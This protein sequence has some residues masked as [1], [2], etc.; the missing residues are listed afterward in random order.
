MKTKLYKQ[1]IFKALATIAL[2]LALV[3]FSSCTNLFDSVNKNDGKAYISVSLGNARRILPTDLAESDITKAELLYGTITA[4][5]ELGTWTTSDGTSAIAAMTADTSKALEVGTY[6]FTLN[7]YVGSDNSY[8]PVETGSVT[9][10]QIVAGTTNS[11]EFTM[12]Y[13][14]SGSGDLE[15]TLK[16]TKDDRVT[17]IQGG[18]FN[19]A[20]TVVTGFE[21]TALAK[22]T[23]D[24]INYTATYSKTDVPVGTYMIKFVLYNDTTVLNTLTDFVVISPECKTTIKEGWTL[25][26]VNTIYTITYNL[27]GGSWAITEPSLKTRN[28]NTGVT[29]PVYTHLWKNGY[30]FAGWYN[31]ETFTG[32]ALT[33]IK[34]GTKGDITLFAKWSNSIYVDTAEKFICAGGKSLLIKSSDGKIYIDD[35]SNGVLDTGEEEIYVT[36]KNALNG[37]GNYSDY[38]LYG[39]SCTENIPSENTS[40]ITMTM[41]AGA[42]KNIYAGGKGYANNGSVT[43]NLSAGTVS[44]NVS[45]Y[46]SDGRTSLY[47]AATSAVNISGSTVIGNKTDEGIEIDSF[48]SGYANVSSALSLSSKNITIL[49]SKTETGTSI[50]ALTNA[51]YAGADYFICRIYDSIE[52]KYNAT[53]SIEKSTTDNTIKIAS[54]VILPDVTITDSSFT[55]GANR[56]TAI[57]TILSV[58]AENGYFTLGSTGLTNATFV[59]GILNGESSY[60]NSC[61]TSNQYR[62]IQYIALNNLI[63]EADASTFVQGITFTRTS[64]NMTVKI[65]LETVPLETINSATVTYFDG[66]FYK[67]VNTSLTWQYAYIAAKNSEFNGLHGYLMTIMS[68]PENMF[69]YNKLM[70][71]NSGQSAW[72]GGNRISP[73]YFNTGKYDGKTFSTDAK[74]FSSLNAGLSCTTAWYWTCGPEAGKCFYTNSTYHENTNVGSYTHETD[75]YIPEGMFAYWNSTKSTTLTE[76]SNTNGNSSFGREICAQ[77]VSGGYWNDLPLGYATET[78]SYII[79]YTPY[80]TQYN[81]ETA[82][83]SSISASKVY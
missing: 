46:G 69:V 57:G 38:T 9:S 60:T 55:L 26:N 7:L 34:A 33:T 4:D 40:I 54:G 3:A 42:L 31:N 59:M 72:I 35:N 6:N 77:Y 20:G 1:N 56:V 28:A 32:D 10:K 58:T 15:L 63:S 12:A 2:A 8:T 11:L 47:K 29:L 65:N 70:D 51:D 19:T 64:T 44:G 80:L 71:G 23:T 62:Y 49:T 13:V 36:N 79:E 50:A 67:F 61:S 30:K 39:G 76:P 24:E 73:T 18:L 5:T 37:T 82:T 27:N 25:S 74:D 17:S 52:K 75:S 68:L 14:T 48:T 21:L 22:S 66:S 81:E 43:I 53:Y 78:K 83:A 41:T 16:W 45:G